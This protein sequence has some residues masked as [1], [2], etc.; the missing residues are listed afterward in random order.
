M[1]IRLTF[2]R[3][4]A[5]AM[6]LALCCF[7]VCTG[8]PRLAAAHSAGGAADV[9]EPDPKAP[10]LSKKC[11]SPASEGLRPDD[12]SRRTVDL[13]TWQWLVPFTTAKTSAGHGPK[14][15]ATGPSRTPPV[16]ISRH[17]LFCTWLT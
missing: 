7:L 2:L 4:A 9:R 15:C 1:D 3:S 5:W 13:R 12:H 10:I 17:I 8:E 11:Q 16:N 14:A 6:G